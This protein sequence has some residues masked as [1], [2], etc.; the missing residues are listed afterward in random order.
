MSLEERNMYQQIILHHNKH[1]NN[2]G[3]VQGAHFH[4]KGVN[5]LCGDQYTVTLQID[6]DRRVVLAMFE[7]EGCAL[8]KA[9]ASIMTQMVHGRNFSEIKELCESFDQY[10]PIIASANFLLKIRLQI[11]VLLAN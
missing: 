6:E 7:G 9:S 3:Q 8:S 10:V 4:S 1:P 5:R 2:Y 11:G